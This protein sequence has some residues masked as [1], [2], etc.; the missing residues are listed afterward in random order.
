MATATQLAQRAGSWPSRSGAGCYCRLPLPRAALLLGL[1]LLLLG[2][3]G[4][5]VCAPRAARCHRRRR[6]QSSYAKFRRR[7]R[8]QGKRS[9]GS[10]ASPVATED[11]MLRQ[12]EAHLQARVALL[13]TRPSILAHSTDSRSAYDAR[14]AGQR[15]VRSR[16]CLRALAS[17][18]CDGGGRVVGPGAARAQHRAAPR[19]GQGAAGVRGGAR[20][21]RGR[22]AAQAGRLRRLLGRLFQRALLPHGQRP[23]AGRDVR[24]RAVVGVHVRA[25]LSR[26]GLAHVAPPRRVLDDRAR[27]RV[28]DAGGRHGVRGGLRAVLLPRAARALRRRPRLHRQGA[29]APGRPAARTLLRLARAGAGAARVRGVRRCTTR[30]ASSG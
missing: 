18:G 23:A 28:R 11:E 4:C 17:G 8:A 10:A 1:L 22:P 5:Q 14:A 3:A 15:R 27:D 29:A 19:S 7:S 20:A 6:T 25:H 30:S 2:P 26:G 16:L 9:T 13:V 24:V 12:V 21:Q